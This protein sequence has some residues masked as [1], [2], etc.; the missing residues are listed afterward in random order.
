MNTPNRRTVLRVGAL[1]VAAAALPIPALASA[2]PDSGVSAELFPLGSV[3]L[4]PGPFRDNTLRTHA[5]LKFLDPERLLH[6]FR[7]NVGLDSTAVPCGGWESPA[8][9]L[10]G[11]STGHVLT[12]LAQA[13]AS[14]GDTAFR[15]KGDHLVAQLA[16]CQD[17][18]QTAGYNPGYL[19][20][21]P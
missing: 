15:T 17:R 21:F 18:A 19:S 2:R 16:I 5:Y 3:S 14:T 4:L 1:A 20:A 6:T 10:R 8:T 12:A 7:L 11:H 9:E 13:Y